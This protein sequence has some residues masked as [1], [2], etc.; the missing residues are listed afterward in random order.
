MW[1]IELYS[2]CTLVVGYEVCIGCLSIVWL[3]VYRGRQVQG[4]GIILGM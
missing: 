1:E 4:Y 3:Y 2:G